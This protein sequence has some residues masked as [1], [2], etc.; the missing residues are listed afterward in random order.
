[1][2]V[3]VAAAVG[4]DGDAQRVGDV[5]VG[6]RLG[7]RQVF[8]VLHLAPQDAHGQFHGV[9]ADAHVFV[10]FLAVHAAQPGFQVG[11]GDRAQVFAVDLFAEMALQ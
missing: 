6:I 4:G 5:A 10:V 9:N 8:V 3:Q 2:P 11:D 7:L 1:M